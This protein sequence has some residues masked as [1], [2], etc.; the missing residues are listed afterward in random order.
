MISR[1]K[2]QK[3]EEREPYA[4]GAQDKKRKGR[5]GPSN[6]RKVAPISK[7]SNRRTK[8][9]R[10]CYIFNVSIA[11]SEVTMPKTSQ[12][13]M[14]LLDPTTII[15]ATTTTDLTIEEKRFSC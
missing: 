12:R 3:H 4:F 11:T 10:K 1:G 5:G 15:V 6:S 9:K 2:I 8:G 13:R 14:M 7:D